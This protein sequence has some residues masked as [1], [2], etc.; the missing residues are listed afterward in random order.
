MPCFALRLEHRSY[1]LKWCHCPTA[2]SVFVC[3]CTLIIH[4]YKISVF[5]IRL[6]LTLYFRSNSLFYLVLFW[7]FKNTFCTSSAL[8]TVSFFF[9][10]TTLRHVVVVRWFRGFVMGE[11]RVR[12]FRWMRQRSRNRWAASVGHQPAGHGHGYGDQRQQGGDDQGDDQPDHR[13]ADIFDTLSGG[14]DIIRVVRPFLP[15]VQRQN[16]VRLDRDL[17]SQCSLDTERVV[18]VGG[19]RR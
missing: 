10:R 17:L 19:Q 15:A 8:Y 1:C 2:K 11:Q 6:F 9:P 13:H 16:C 12:E 3:V 14:S 4:I 7:C 5:F 18:V